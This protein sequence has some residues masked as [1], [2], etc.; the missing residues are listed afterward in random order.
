MSPSEWAEYFFLSYGSTF[1]LYVVA[2][3]AALWTIQSN[4]RWF[5]YVPIPIMTLVALGTAEALSER[6]SLWGVALMVTSPIALAYLALVVL[7][8]GVVRYSQRKRK[9]SRS[10]DEG[11]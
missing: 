8:A 9:A 2:Q 11:S 3:I 1:T 6:S 10:R 7:V 5:L 4:A